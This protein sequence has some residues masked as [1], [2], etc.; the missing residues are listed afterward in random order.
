MKIILAQGNPG[1]E[2]AATRHNVGWQALDGFAGEHHSS[3]AS[4]PKFLADIAE[5]TVAGEKVLLVKPQTFYNDTG[6]AA[7][8]I[9]DFYKLESAD[10]LVIHDELALPLGTI[11]VREQGS[12][13]GNNGIKS[14][15][16]HIGPLYARLR[17]GVANE[18]SSKIAAADFVL[19]RFNA[20]EQ[21]QLTKTIIP[22]AI[23]LIDQFC[24][25]TLAATSHT[26]DQ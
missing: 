22:K 21:Q 20:N 14:L 18:H 3:F 1:L 2:Y 6:R 24:R 15:N 19:G 5:T 16:A 4:K 25:G 10:V 13:A 9:L 8:A 26:L 7:R 17:I 23:E 11:R 12:D